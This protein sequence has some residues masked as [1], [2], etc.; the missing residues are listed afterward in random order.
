MVPRREGLLS[1]LTLPLPFVARVYPSDLVWLSMVL[2]HQGLL[3]LLTL[4]EP[5]VV[6]IHIHRF[7]SM[8]LLTLAQREGH[9][10]LLVPPLPPPA[11]HYHYR[12]RLQLLL[13]AR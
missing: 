8:Q 12:L 10:F 7:A 2:R 5:D 6:R 11:R 1:L 9:L 4:P 13:L 3:S